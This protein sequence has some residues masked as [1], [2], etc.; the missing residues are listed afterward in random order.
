MRVLTKVTGKPAFTSLQ[1]AAPSV[2]RNTL[3]AIVVYK[4]FEFCGSIT[5]ATTPCQRPGDHANPKF[6]GLQLAPPSVLFNTPTDPPAYR[7]SG[8]CGSTARTP[9]GKHSSHPP[10]DSV[11]T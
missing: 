7:V 3:P 9:T 5:R 10:T 2:L 6:M 11:G 4:L 1:V 8:R